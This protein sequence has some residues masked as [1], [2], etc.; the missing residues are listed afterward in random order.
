MKNRKVFSPASIP[1]RTSKGLFCVTTKYR[2]SVLSTIA[3]VPSM[4][5]NSR[6]GSW[7]QAQTGALERHSVYLSPANTNVGISWM[8]SV[9]GLSNCGGNHITKGVG[10]GCLVLVWEAVLSSVTRMPMYYHLSNRPFAK[11]PLSH[12]LLQNTGDSLSHPSLFPSSNFTR[13][14]PFLSWLDYTT[15]ILILKIQTRE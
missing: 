10:T 2:C 13:L 11:W 4:N 7:V 9:A 1:E 5:V 15:D 3:L 6:N 14:T 8:V 12:F